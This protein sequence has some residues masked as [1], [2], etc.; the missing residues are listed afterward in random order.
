MRYDITRLVME[1]EVLF[2]LRWFIYDLEMDL[3]IIDEPQN[4]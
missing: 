1:V 2:C 4:S 3:L